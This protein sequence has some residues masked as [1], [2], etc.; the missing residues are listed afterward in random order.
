VGLYAADS[1]QLDPNLSTQFDVTE[2]MQNRNGNLP[3]DRPHVVR[4]DGYYQ[5]Q[6]GDHSLTSGLGFLGQ[7]GIP[8]TPLGRDSLMG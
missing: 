5:L 7:S 6:F 1:D 8:I 4:A 3:N 2:L